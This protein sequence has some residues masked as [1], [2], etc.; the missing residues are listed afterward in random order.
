MNIICFVVYVSKFSIYES[1]NLYMS[2][3]GVGSSTL[4]M[5]IICC[6][7]YMRVITCTCPNMEF[8]NVEAIVINK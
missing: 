1:D 6:V 7:V 5:N 2:K 8:T 3:Y 4:T